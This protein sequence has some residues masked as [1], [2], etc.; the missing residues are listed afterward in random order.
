MNCFQVHR[1]H[2]PKLHLLAT[3]VC[4]VCQYSRLTPFLPGIAHS[5][6]IRD[7]LPSCRGWRTPTVFETYPL[8]AGNSALP[9]YSRLTPF[10]PGIAHSHSIRDLPPSCRE[11]HTPTVFVTYPLLAVN[12]ATPQYSRLTPFL[13]GMAH[14]HSIRDLPPSCRG[15]RTPTASGSECRPHSWP[16]EPRT[17]ERTN[18]GETIYTVYTRRNSTR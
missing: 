5:H 14:S 15:W 9:R 2:S 13:P 4:K 7:L 16:A 12:G 17:P 18:I 8:L 6:S 3:T 1:S 11:W 10:L